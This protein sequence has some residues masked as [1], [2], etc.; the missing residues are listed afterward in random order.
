MGEGA[1]LFGLLHAV[2]EPRKGPYEFARRLAGSVCPIGSAASARWRRQRWRPAPPC[3][4]P[5][6]PAAPFWSSVCRREAWWFKGVFRSLQDEQEREAKE[7]L[8][9]IL[10]E[11]RRRILALMVERELGPNYNQTLLEEFRAL[12]LPSMRRVFHTTP[13]DEDASVPPTTGFDLEERFLFGPESAIVARHSRAPFDAWHHDGL[14]STATWD[15]IGPGTHVLPS[16]GLAK[17]PQTQSPAG[18]SAD[19]F[20]NTR[21][22]RY[23]EG[24]MSREPAATLA[25][26]DHSESTYE[27]FDRLSVQ[28][29]NGLSVQRMILPAEKRTVHRAPTGGIDGGMERGRFLVL[30]RVTPKYRQDSARRLD[31]LESVRDEWL[32]GSDAAAES[33][34]PGVF[35][36]WLRDALR[37]LRVEA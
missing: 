36:K 2:L 4:W 24:S 18:W 15:V 8:L 27:Y 13:A 3:P 1:Q 19:E 30:I 26:R 11:G 21:F 14:S 34:T 5:R 28:Q 37:R 6:N 23:F 16:L 7:R 25:A 35:A 20:H 22:W 10:D 32:N 17:D 31:E 29:K 12:D 9:K 33:L